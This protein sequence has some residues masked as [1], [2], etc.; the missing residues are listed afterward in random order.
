MFLHL[1]GYLNRGSSRS[2]NSI[3]AKEESPKEYQLT[4]DE[5]EFTKEYLNKDFKKY[6]HLES[7]IRDIYKKLD[8]ED[9]ERHSKKKK[10]GYDVSGV[11]KLS[12]IEIERL[13]KSLFNES[14]NGD[15]NYYGDNINVKTTLVVGGSS[16]SPSSSSL[17]SSGSKK[18]TDLRDYE[19]QKPDYII[20][21]SEFLQKSNELLSKII[22]KER[23]YKKP[24]GSVVIGGGGGGSGSGS[25][26]GGINGSG[27]VG[28]GSIRDID[29]RLISDYNR[30]KILKDST[31]SSSSSSGGSN[32][33]RSKDELSLQNYCG[34]IRLRTG[35]LSRS[36]DDKDS[37]KLKYDIDNVRLDKHHS[38]HHHHHHQQHQH[39]HH[40]HHRQNDKNYSTS[41]DESIDRTT[42]IEKN[43]DGISGYTKG[44]AYLL[45]G[46][47]NQG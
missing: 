23:N 10:D 13:R 27:G 19:L 11:A 7:D 25:G 42:G 6:D 39:H 4:R 20:K 26:V 45:A 8:Y 3:I 2:P 9:Y 24:E 38:H 40:H 35:S 22:T 14:D 44:I 41:E 12:K 47:N 30:I 37:D 15:N 31:S 46:Y 34:S 36:Y 16:P 32:G 43:V 17:S 21:N 29:N 28:S 18:T 33:L 5:F 1:S